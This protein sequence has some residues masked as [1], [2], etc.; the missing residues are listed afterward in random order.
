[1]PGSGETGDDYQIWFPIVEYFYKACFGLAKFTMRYV[2]L[3]EGIVTK[4][5]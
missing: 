5:I 1:M 4:F 3:S 2:I